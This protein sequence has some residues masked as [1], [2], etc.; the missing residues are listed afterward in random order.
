MSDPLAAI[1]VCHVG[2]CGCVDRKCYPAPALR[3]NGGAMSAI[4]VP[5][6]S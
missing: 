4:T 6:D 1:N 5:H 2:G 3:G